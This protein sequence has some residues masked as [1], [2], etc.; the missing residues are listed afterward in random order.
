MTNPTWLQLMWNGI[1][2]DGV[3]SLAE[4]RYLKGLKCLELENNFIGDLGACALANSPNC[5]LLDRLTV[6]SIYRTSRDETLGPEAVEAL[7][8]R[9]GNRLGL[10]IT[11][12][13]P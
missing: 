2:S 7:K 1:T 12:E 8:Q 6:G 5:D 10:S 13:Q 3:M 9:F 11:A 4:S